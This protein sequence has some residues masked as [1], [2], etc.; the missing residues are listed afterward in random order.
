MFTKFSIKK[1]DMNTHAQDK[2]DSLMNMAKMFTDNYVQQV[3]LAHLIALQCLNE[4]YKS[5]SLESARID[6]W[7]DVMREFTYITADR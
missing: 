1:N 5:S 7:E 2:V 4:S 3:T 6:F